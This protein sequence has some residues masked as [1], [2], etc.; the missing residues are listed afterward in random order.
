MSDIRELVPFSALNDSIEDQY[1]AE[2]FGFKDENVL[3]KRFFDVQDLVD[4]EGHGLTR[5]LRG[6]FTEPTI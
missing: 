3:I 2:G 6:D 5:P 1:I 4:L